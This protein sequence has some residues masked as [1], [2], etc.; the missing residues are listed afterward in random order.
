MG[1]NVRAGVLGTPVE[2]SC[3]L[4]N[5][6]VQNRSTKSMQLTDLLEQAKHIYGDSYMWVLYEIFEA[7]ADVTKRLNVL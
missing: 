5:W 7:P 6:G 2:L 4:N 3:D 1:R